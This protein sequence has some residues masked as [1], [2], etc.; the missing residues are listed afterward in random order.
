VRTI[1]ISKKLL[2]NCATG[3]LVTEVYNHCSGPA[4]AVE[5]VFEET[6]LDYRQKHGPESLLMM[7]YTPAC[8][9]EDIVTLIRQG[10]EITVKHGDAD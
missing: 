7:E 9:V 10:F 6:S 1:Y 2:E 4:C 3:T 8:L 5:L